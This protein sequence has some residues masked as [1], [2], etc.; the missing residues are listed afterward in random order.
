MWSKLFPSRFA[1]LKA[2]ILLFLSISLLMRIS[3]LVWNF[4]EVDTRIFSLLKTFGTGFLFDIGTVS[5]FAIPYLIYLVLFPIKW[6]GSK[7]DKFIT[8]FG[9][10]LGVLIIYFSFFG[11]FTFWDEFQ[12]RYN[13]IAVDYLIT[14]TKL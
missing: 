14:P 6:Y 8:F 2:F 1:L 3:F 4:G 10:S 9:F 13:F 12:R 5:F 11:E 7:V